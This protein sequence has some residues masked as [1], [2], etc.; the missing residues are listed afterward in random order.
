MKNK[1]L[2]IRVSESERAYI[3]QNCGSNMSKWVIEK[4]VPKVFEDSPKSH[5]K[6][7]EFIESE[8]AP[9]RCMASYCNSH[10]TQQKFVN[11]LPVWLCVEHA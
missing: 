4:L 2:T 5:R 10:K 8:E 7:L 11:G 1:Y 6:S 9:K 3:K